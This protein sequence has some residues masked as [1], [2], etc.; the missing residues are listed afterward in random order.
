MGI[1]GSFMEEAC[2]RRACADDG[3]TARPCGL[4]GTGFMNEVAT[5][6]V[7]CCREWISWAS[8]AADSAERV[9]RPACPKMESELTAVRMSLVHRPTNNV[10]VLLRTFG[11][12]WGLPK[13][14]G[15]GR[16][17][18][19]LRRK[20]PCLYRFPDDFLQVASTECPPSRVA[21]PSAVLVACRPSWRALAPDVHDPA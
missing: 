13:N 1:L 9:G 18:P 19:W 14:P 12:G 7:F 15:I 11:S 6:T 8:W 16:V 2:T 4:S 10:E 3:F 20:D 5:G 17:P 21:I